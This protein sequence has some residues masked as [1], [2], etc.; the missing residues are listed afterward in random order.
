MLYLI[1]SLIFPTSCFGS[2]EESDSCS[3]WIRPG[4]QHLRPFDQKQQLH[5]GGSGETVLPH[6]LL[7]QLYRPTGRAVI[8]AVLLSDT[9]SADTSLKTAGQIVTV[10]RKGHSFSSSHFPLC[11]QSL[12]PPGD[13][14]ERAAAEHLVSASVAHVVGLV[15]LICALNSE[16]SSFLSV[17]QGA[18][19]HARNRHDFLPGA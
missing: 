18:E 13:I 11:L 3:C 12:K 8:P 7:G 4:R 10:Y 2:S 15:V 16:Q 19:S 6:R 9:F 5:E 14:S 1:S 17:Q